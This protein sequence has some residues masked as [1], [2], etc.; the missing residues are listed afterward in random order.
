VPDVR[1]WLRERLP[2]YMVPSR[3]VFLET[4]PRTSSGKID[5][6]ALLDRAPDEAPET[7]EAPRTPV[8]E[9]V[10]G[11]W[12]EVLER[13]KVGLG[14]SFFDLGGHSLM[15]S[16]TLARLRS[17]FGVDLPLRA[18]FLDPTVEG[19][20]RQVEEARR[21]QV[22]IPPIPRVSRDR[23]LP[24]SYA[25]ERLWL[26]DQLQP[27]NTAYNSFL[28]LTLSG[29]PVDHPALPALETALAE[30]VRRHESLRTRFVSGPDGP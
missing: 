15:A 25:Q 24:L 19:V 9:I 3:V 14:Q 27:G 13:E 1:A 6:R 22:E 17:A 8:E 29:G 4:L 16:R 18:F 12:S 21:T 20:A 23:R 30:I 5:R 2:D 28:A 26:V 11:I 10:A 7:F